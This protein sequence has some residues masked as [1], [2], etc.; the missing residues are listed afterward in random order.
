MKEVLHKFSVFTTLCL[1]PAGCDLSTGED[2]EFYDITFSVGE[3]SGTPPPSRK[4]S[5]ST[6]VRPL[7]V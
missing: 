6:A 2:D 4:A 3:G 5:A 1:L 7:R